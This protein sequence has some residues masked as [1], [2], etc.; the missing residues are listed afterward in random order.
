MMS[1]RIL[2]VED[3]ADM[4]LGLALRLQSAG[5]TV[6]SAMDGDDAVHVALSKQPDLIL[7]DIGLPGQSGHSVARTLAAHD[8]TR[9]IPIIFLTAR[10]ETQHRIKA[11][12]GRAAAFLVKP[13]SPDK[14]LR[15]IE[16]VVN[17][18]PVPTES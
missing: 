14:L 8:D 7:L 18:P 15:T 17:P 11:S 1:A 2:V 10:H 12:E 4:H 3:N 6:L 9:A 16:S 5:H 13:C